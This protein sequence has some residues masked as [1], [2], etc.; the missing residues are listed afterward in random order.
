MHTYIRSYMNVCIQ[1]YAYIHSHMNVHIIIMCIYTCMYIYIYIH[2]EA[3][4]YVT[5]GD[6][7]TSPG[8]I[9]IYIYTKHI[10][11]QTGSPWLTD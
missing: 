6:L 5:K 4:A 1:T 11:R 2:T 7:N 10:D 9:Y 8:Y 3:G